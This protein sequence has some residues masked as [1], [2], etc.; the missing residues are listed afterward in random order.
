MRMTWL[1]GWLVATWVVCPGCKN[2]DLNG[3]AVEA[4]GAEAGFPVDTRESDAALVTVD[5]RTASEVSVATSDAPIGLDGE[6]SD[7]DGGPVVVV[8]AV[9]AA[10]PDAPPG[11]EAGTAVEAGSPLAGC[12]ASSEFKNC[13]LYCTTAGLACQAKGCGGLT[14]RKYQSK[15]NCEASI[16]ASG[17]SSQ[18]CS[19]TIL[20]DSAGTTVR[21]CCK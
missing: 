15:S 12:F 17:T 6:I 2:P 18:D 16:Y 5:A 10:V 9:D 3:F 14:Y 20:S 7:A 8:V 19:A 1:I 21:C 4:G 13:N 11:A